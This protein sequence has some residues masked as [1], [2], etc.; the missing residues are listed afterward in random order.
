[1]TTSFAVAT[2][3]STRVSIDSPLWRA[4]LSMDWNCAMKKQ[5]SVLIVLVAY[6]SLAAFPA[7]H[8]AQGERKPEYPLAIFAIASGERIQERARQFAEASGQPDQVETVLNILTM[9]LAKLL[10]SDGF[11]R[12]RPVGIMNFSWNADEAE[13]ALAELK[14][15]SLEQFYDPDELSDL[16]LQEPVVFFPVRDSSLFVESLEKLADEKFIPTPGQPGHFQDAKGKV[17]PLRIVGRY[18]VYFGDDRP[19]RALPDLDELLRPLVVNRDAVLSFQA[20]GIPK[21]LRESGGELIQ[22]KAA[23][24]LQ[25]FDSESDL[26]FR[27]R[28]ALGALQQE[29]IEIAVSQIDEINIGVKFDPNNSTAAMEFDLV[30]PRNGKLARLCSALAVKQGF[31]PVPDE[32]PTLELALSTPIS[33]RMAKPLI[34]AL[35]TRPDIPGLWRDQVR[36]T[37]AIGEIFGSLASTLEAGHLDFRLTSHRGEEHTDYLLGLRITRGNQLAQAIPVALEQLVAQ[38]D[39]QYA[40]DAIEQI[41]VHRMTLGRVSE[42]FDEWDAPPGADH[43]VWFA[44]GRQTL[45]LAWKSDVSPEIPVAMR[46]ALSAPPVPVVRPRFPF[47]ARLHAESWFSSPEPGIGDDGANDIRKSVA[48]AEDPDDERRAEQL[49]QL[50][51]VVQVSFREQPDGLQLDVRPTDTGLKIRVTCEEGLITWLAVILMKTGL[52]Q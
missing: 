8:G 33:Q 52:S 2:F 28:T 20:R 34:D 13:Q 38:V 23:A 36:M 51:Q 19:N 21:L 29:L 32:E 27:W 42:L 47:L 5:C 6:A 40:V 46:N 7:S 4:W 39:A 15:A 37:D 16:L 45:W 22:M 44:V 17:Q 18:V 30:G 12:T 25:R 1:M 14:D 50:D 24:T 31:F 26:E 11:D 48:T 41:P 43:P 35:K 3:A 9:G 49:R 10:E